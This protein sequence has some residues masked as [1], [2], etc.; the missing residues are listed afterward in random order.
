MGEPEVIS[1]N[2]LSGHAP[3]VDDTVKHLA[4]GRDV[5]LQCGE[6]A[7]SP[8]ACK[9]L[10]GSGSGVVIILYSSP[11]GIG[12]F[13]SRLEALGTPSAF[14]HP[15]RSR[16]DAISAESRFAAK[17]L[18]V[19]ALP[20][21]K[22]LTHS[23]ANTADSQPVTA[24][25]IDDAVQVADSLN[26][27]FRPERT[28]TS[29]LRDVPRLAV[30]R[31]LDG[32]A[33]ENAVAT[34]GLRN[35]T[36]VSTD[37][38]TINLAFNCHLRSSPYEAQLLDILKAEK[39]RGLIYLS[40]PKQASDLV[41]WLA[42]QGLQA[43]EWHDDVVDDKLSATLGS[44]RAGSG[45]FTAAV[46]GGLTF[47]D[48]I[49]VDFTVHMATPH[50]TRLFFDEIACLRRDQ[51][52]PSCHV[53]YGY[54]DVT[55]AAKSFNKEM[56]EQDRER[57]IAAAIEMFRYADAFQ[58][59][60][61][62]LSE[63]VGIVTD[64]PCGRCDNCREPPKMFDATEHTILA[65][66]C[67]Y[68]APGCGATNLINTLVGEAKTVETKKG[69][70]E[71]NIYGKGAHITKGRWWSVYRQLISAGYA[72]VDGKGH[73]DLSD[74][75][76]AFFKTRNSATKVMLRDED[77]RTYEEIRAARIE[78]KLE[79]DDD[80]TRAYFEELN[81]ERKTIAEGLSTRE[82][83]VFADEFVLAMARTVPV[84][85]EDLVA[86]PGI[87]PMNAE[88]YGPRMLKAI[89]RAGGKLE[90]GSVA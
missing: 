52:K 63:N 50:S 86:I 58:C 71:L 15:D 85:L 29:V 5:Y 78:Q 45:A 3:A 20:I 38:P 59:R 82:Y 55:D 14:I 42:I 83:F 88:L 25:V 67:I 36:I 10:A 66:S 74:K 37:I 80:T 68:R 22:F 30:T 72:S 26:G 53:I 4:G 6:A 73:L 32:T 9:S 7:W 77:E 11:M 79:G 28:V 56:A 16:N 35:P 76:R 54:K 61:V 90:P 49:P 12:Q 2:S 81:K 84:T 23:F 40:S 69:L 89:R 65:L 17:S 24:V 34:L 21:S 41:A 87:R 70:T 19:F 43:Y 75:G 18:K 51:G 39:G 27:G 44:L 60:E 1:S 62:V 13:I 8:E 57:S 64:Q 48:N 46:S 33:R 47:P 31:S